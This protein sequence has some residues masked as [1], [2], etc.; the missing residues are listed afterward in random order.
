MCSYLL[1]VAFHFMLFF[2]KARCMRIGTPPPAEELAARAATAAEALEA[3]P[4]PAYNPDLDKSVASGGEFGG[5][6]GKE[7][8]SPLASHAAAGGLEVADPLAPP[9][10]LFRYRKPRH[11]LLLAG[12]DIVLPILVAA[13]GMFFCV[14]TLVLLF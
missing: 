3:A 14:S 1:P 13:L 10:L 4:A 2:G 12:Y 9:G 7:P 11:P 6:V 5:S 8:T